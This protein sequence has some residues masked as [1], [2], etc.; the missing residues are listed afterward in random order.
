MPYSERDHRNCAVH[1]VWA[2]SNFSLPHPP[3]QVVDGLRDEDKGG[4]PFTCFWLEPAGA[5]GRLSRGG[6]GQA[7]TTVRSADPGAVCQQSTEKPGVSVQVSQSYLP[8]R[9]L[10][11]TQDAA[12]ARY[13]F[14]PRLTRHGGYEAH[15]ASAMDGLPR[16]A[17]QP[18]RREPL[19]HSSAFAF[20][21]CC[22]ACCI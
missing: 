11:T 12:R 3:L 8:V 21:I 1:K 9:L 18:Q 15:A 5:N 16:P 6:T 20:I 10:C 22:P 14:W 13:R 4:S 7:L 19:P 17:S 2:P